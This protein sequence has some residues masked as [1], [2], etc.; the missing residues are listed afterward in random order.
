MS[1]I[2]NQRVLHERFELLPGI[3]LA[4]EDPDAD[5]Y[6]TSM[7]WAAAT[8]SEPVRTYTADEIKIDL[9][10]RRADTGQLVLGGES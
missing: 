8:D 5:A 1:V 2:F 9:E 7:G 10:T 6:F 4:F 3:P